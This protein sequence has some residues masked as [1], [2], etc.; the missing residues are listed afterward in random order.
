MRLV[1]ERLAVGARSPSVGLGALLGLALCA[2][3]PARAQEAV[4][5]GS[6]SVHATFH[7]VGITVRVSGD[8]EQNAT[9]ALEVS[10]NG[11]TWRAAHRL[12]RAAPD[13]FVGSALF[14]DPGTSYQ[15]RVTLDDPDG[16]TNGTLQ[17]GGTTRALEVPAS[18]GA[19]LHVDPTGNDL[20]GDGSAGSPFASLG[21]ALETAQAGDRV[22]LHAGIYHEEVTLPRGGA[23]GAPLTIAS[24]GDGP[25]V[26]DGADPALKAAA[27]WTD[28]GGGLWSASAAETR[29][30][31]VS[32]LRLWRY[33]SLGDLE[34]DALGTNGGFTWESGTLTVR[35][36][37]SAAPG[38]GREI[39][40]STL[41]RALWLEGTPHVVI[42]GLTIRCYGAEEYS[43]G[44]MVRDGS[45]AVWIVGNVFENVMPGVWVKNDVD[46]LTVMDNEFS[47]RGLAEFPWYE[48]KARGGMESG[49]LA[50]D[51]QYDGQGIVFYRN[52]V[53]DSFDGLRICGDQAMTTPNNADVRA[54]SFVHL[55]DD[56]IE[57][58]GTCSNIRILENRFEEALVGVSVAPAVGGPTWILRNL[59]VD[60]KNVSPDTDWSTRALKFNVGDSRPSGE[61]FV[62]HNTATTYEPAQAAFNVTDD[63]LW[64]A[65]HLANNLWQGTDYAFSYENSGDEPFF[66]DY[67]LFFSTGSRLV[68]YQGTSYGTVGEYTTGTGQCAHCLAGDPRFTDGT[69]GDYSLGADSPALDVGVVLWGVNDDFVGSGPDIGALER[70]GEQP[71]LP[72]AGVRPDAAGPGPDGSIGPD[73]D[74]STDTPSEGK[75]CGCA[76][77]DR[78]TPGLPFVLLGLGLWFV[79]RRCRPRP[80]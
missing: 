33:E 11:A 74:G 48:V 59:M 22:L 16:V 31:A 36:P 56:G 80:A 34:A 57:T 77:G 24:A 26:L 18:G 64:I 4:T 49:A 60:L 21:R 6:I 62:Y 76:A 46:D 15:V 12:S 1:D 13:R 9:A 51:D 42:R 58:D 45:H 38:P 52:L 73:P 78:S 32:G 72:D 8:T 71:P 54:N 28:A 50:V 35:L 47:D 37:G 17:A 53:H 25:A 2:A 63:S 61:V 44:L 65:V 68:R 43:E 10:L 55:G 7:T 67:D 69:G 5:G 66:Q 19:T 20:S 40:V 41:G 3:L 23:E 14:L 27:A 29:Y 75:G 39:Q 70:G 30:V 79:R